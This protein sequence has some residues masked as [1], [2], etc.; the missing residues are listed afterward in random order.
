[1]TWLAE[2]RNVSKTFK[3]IEVLR[4]VNVTFERG[5]IFG[6]VGPNGSGKSVL[7]RLLCGFTLPT[8]GE[9]R[10]HPDYRPPGTEFPQRFGVIIDGPGYVGHWSGVKNL[11]NLAAIRKLVSEETVRETMR[12]VGLDDGS[13]MAV[14]R[15]SM[16]MKQKL[17]LAQAV[18]EGQEI[19]VL[20]EPFNALDSAASEMLTT[21]L[22][23][24]RASGGTVLFTSH[25]NDD[26]DKLSDATYRINDGRLQHIPAGATT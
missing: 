7:F 21:L 20:D 2:F 24:H 18:M 23:D 26:V 25:R 16:G 11:I 1:M 15:Y 3:G 6:I 4:D 10:I 22:L 17:A 14:S 12:R 5:R 8:S 13:K 9:V 19:L